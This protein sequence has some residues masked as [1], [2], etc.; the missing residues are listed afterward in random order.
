MKLDVRFIPN[1]CSSA[2]PGSFISFTKRCEILL[3]F[4]ASTCDSHQRRQETQMTSTSY[5]GVNCC[6]T[7]R[8]KTLCL[9]Y[10]ALRS[11]M[12]DGV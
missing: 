2:Q 1:E 7:G 9:V 5:E 12:H 3:V 11:V 6:E 8:L 4:Y 10:V